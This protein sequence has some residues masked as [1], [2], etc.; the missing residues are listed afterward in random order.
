MPPGQKE[1][2]Y[3]TNKNDATEET[4][5]ANLQHTTHHTNAKGSKADCQKQDTFFD[6]FE[7]FEFTEHGISQKNVGLR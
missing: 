2:Q 6:R 5:K 1:T 3:R 7:G 4:Q